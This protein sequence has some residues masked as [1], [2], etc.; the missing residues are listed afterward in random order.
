MP[1]I[2]L[3]IEYNGSNY[4][5]WQ[6]QPDYKA[7]PSIQE[8]LENALSMVANSKIEVFCAGRTDRGVHAT[9]QIVH[10]DYTKTNRKLDAWLL[11]GNSLLPDD[12]SINWVKE[13]PPD[14]HA[15]FS[16]VARR[17]NYYFYISPAKRGLLNNRALW[18]K[19]TLDTKAM[20]EACNYLIGEQDFSALRSSQC[21][22]KSP[23]RNVIHAKILSKDH[24]I[25]LD[26]KANAFLH[27][28]VRNIVGCLLEIGLGNKPAEWMLEV[29][30]SKDR[31]K[32][33]KTAPPDGL[34]LVEVT[35]PEQYSFLTQNNPI[36]I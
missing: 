2:A 10:F 20:Q 15:R 7:R 16:A 17:Y 8:L 18:V 12:I 27:H 19:K 5:G 11:G 26:I 32:A 9:E 4:Q 23:Y 31:T 35:Y 14:F 29:L 33:A 21:E 3:S 34:Y 25:V 30:K 28:M 6:I 1:R 36:H 24:F 13:V 22:S